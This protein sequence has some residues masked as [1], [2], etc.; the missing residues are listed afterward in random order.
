MATE[1]PNLK[2][3]SGAEAI[4][5]FLGGAALGALVVGVPI[6]YG[7]SIALNP[8]QISIAGLLVISCGVLSNIWGEK[9]IDSVTQLL[10]SFTP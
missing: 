5:R 4:Y 3:R 2:S 9:F 8:V 7:A 6:S 1:D 10:N